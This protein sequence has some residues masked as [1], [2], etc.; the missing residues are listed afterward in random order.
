[1][2]TTLGRANQNLDAGLTMSVDA[3]TP[4]ALVVDDED[5]IRL[6]FQR[7]LKALGW[8]SVA[9]ES[10]K[11]A[12]EI[13]GVRHFD[14]VFMDLAM[15]EMNGVETFR[16]IRE[17][18][19]TIFVVIATGYPG[20]D[21]MIEALEVGPFAVMRKPFSVDELKILLPLLTRF[22]SRE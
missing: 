14:I 9:V 21:L 15:P 20:S 10:G 19:P 13:V 5:N 11:D 1:M 7:A 6:F 17:V 18:A 3:L 4:T 16:K 22:S 8:D 2:T 12:I